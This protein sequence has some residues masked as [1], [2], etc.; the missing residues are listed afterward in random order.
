[1]ERV[2]TGDVGPVEGSELALSV[3][4]AEAGGRIPVGDKENDSLLYVFSGEG[5]LTPGDGRPLTRGTAALVLAGEVAGI[6]AGSAGIGAVLA[7]V[8][9]NVDRHAPLGAREAMVAVEESE[10]ARAIGTRS[11]QVLF[12]PHN[13]ST[14]ATLFVGSLPP[15]S[16]P[17][18]YHLYD[19]IVWVPDG[20]G[21]LHLG[22]GVEQ[23]RA[24]SAFRLRPREAHYL[25]NTSADRELVV[26]GFFT[27]AG[28]PAAAYLTEAPAP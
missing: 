14:R 8:G 24:G 28:S 1:M 16:V 9:P 12:G 25:E 20:P 4:R 21:K 17:W 6:E 10:A 27:P 13:G 18:H 3:V 11:Y 2:T 5:S 19:E 15:G 22:N 23:L 7:T 26:V